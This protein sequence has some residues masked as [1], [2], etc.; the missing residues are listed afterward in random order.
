MII[1]VFRLNELVYLVDSAEC[2]QFKRDNP[3][4]EEIGI[5]PFTQDNDKPVI[6]H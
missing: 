4:S 2:Y 5:V 3:E 6:V 1:H